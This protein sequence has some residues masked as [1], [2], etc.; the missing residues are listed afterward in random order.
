MCVGMDGICGSAT[1][2]SGGACPSPGRRRGCQRQHL[3]RVDRCSRVDSRC[4]PVD[5]WCCSLNKMKHT[6]INRLVLLIPD[7]DISSDP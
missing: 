3:P 1:R 5:S 4:L 2:P 6:G 7:T